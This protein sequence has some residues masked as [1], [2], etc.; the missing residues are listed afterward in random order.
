MNG[1]AMLQPLHFHYPQHLSAFSFPLNI[2]KGL[3]F[4]ANPVLSTL[5][6]WYH[7][8]FLQESTPIHNKVEYAMHYDAKRTHAA[9]LNIQ[10]ETDTYQQNSTT[11]NH[12]FK[13]HNILITPFTNLISIL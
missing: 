8:W 5:Y 1:M 12:Q 11:N 9:G 6:T 2:F 3:L 4:K 13:K 7:Y 10:Y